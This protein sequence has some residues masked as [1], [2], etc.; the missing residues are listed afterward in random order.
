MKS[1][2]SQ[3]RL[4]LGVFIVLLA[5]VALG[6]PIDPISGSVAGMFLVTDALKSAPI[7]NRDAVPLVLN[8]GRVERA[9]L[10]EAI[11]V[12]TSTSAAA[13]GSTYTLVSVPSSARI[14]DLI[15]ICGAQGTACTLDVGVY[16][17]TQDGGAA[18]DADF[19]ATA[20]D[21]SAALA[22]TNITNESGTNTIA[23]Q[24]QPLWQAAGMSADPKSTL[25][26]VGVIVG[27]VVSGNPICL[28]ARYADNSN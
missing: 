3:H 19:F 18:V 7:T 21:V 24:Q 13:T 2:L 5:M 26:I 11:G 4:Q 15:L 12:A 22:G 20:V 28:K 17:N 25:D 23:K 6:V 8:D 14:T 1:Y 16:R 10:K 9:N 27:P